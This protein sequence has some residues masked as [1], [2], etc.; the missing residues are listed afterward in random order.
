[1]FLR[2]SLVEKLA[3]RVKD[4]KAKSTGKQDNEMCYEWCDILANF[5]LL[6][7]ISDIV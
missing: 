5:I 2:S 4:L 3:A 6:S 1:M 7:S